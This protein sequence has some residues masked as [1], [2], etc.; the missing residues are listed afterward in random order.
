MQLDPPWLDPARG[1][2][3]MRARD[4]HF[5]IN[6]DILGDGK[7]HR[8]PGWSASVQRIKAGVKRTSQADQQ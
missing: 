8:H 3:S 5:I 7:L 2:V 4:E 1:E 6:P